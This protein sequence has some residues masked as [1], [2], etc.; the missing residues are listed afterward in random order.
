MLPVSSRISGPTVEEYV[1]RK[2]KKNGFPCWIVQP[3]AR[4]SNQANRDVM[5]CYT[6]K[7]IKKKV[8]RREKKIQCSEK[9]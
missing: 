2:A 8:T 6:K 9:N 5:L 3:T 4:N 7:A 1:A